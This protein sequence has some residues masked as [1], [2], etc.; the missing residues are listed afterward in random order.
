MTIKQL[1]KVEDKAKEV[2]V[3]SP[4]LHFDVENKDFSEIVSVNL[5]QKTK[6]RYVVP[7]SSAVKR[8]MVAYKK[9]YNIT[10]EEMFNNFLLLPESDFNPFITEVAIYNGSSKSPVAVTAP[11]REDNNDVIKFKKATA[12][13]MAK[14]FKSIWRKYMRKNP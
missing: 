13:E 10:E 5:G 14:E 6:Y 3:I 11:A 7:A 9:M 1:I 4:S 2:W 8:N 12:V